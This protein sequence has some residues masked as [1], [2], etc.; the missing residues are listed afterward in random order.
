MVLKRTVKRD[1]QWVQWLFHTSSYSESHLTNP[2]WAF[3]LIQSCSNLIVVVTQLTWPQ[4]QQKKRNCVEGLWGYQSLLLV[5]LLYTQGGLA[6]EQVCSWEL[7]GCCGCAGEAGTKRAGCRL[8]IR[9]GWEG[10]G[11]LVSGPAQNMLVNRK[12]AVLCCK[13]VGQ[14]LLAHGQM[15]GTPAI[16]GKVDRV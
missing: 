1:H 3:L 4:K 13:N 16:S 15:G 10:G 6:D 9:L 2:S 12:A 8:Q 5:V 11:P 14:H 7:M